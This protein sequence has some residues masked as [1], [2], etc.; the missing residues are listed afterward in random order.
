MLSD[1]G[2][3]AFPREGP[4]TTGEA[5]PLPERGHGPAA[6]QAD[7]A[8]PPQGGPPGSAVPIPGEEAVI[9]HARLAAQALCSRILEGSALVEAVLAVHGHGAQPAAGAALA[10][11]ARL[12]W[13]EGSRR[14]AATRQAGLFQLQ[15]AQQSVVVRLPWKQKPKGSV[16]YRRRLKAG[17]QDTL[18]ISG[19]GAAPSPW[20]KL[21]PGSGYSLPLPSPHAE[22]KLLPGQPTKKPNQPKL[23]R[24]KSKMRMEKN[25]ATHISS[26]LGTHAKKPLL[27][28]GQAQPNSALPGKK[29]SQGQPHAFINRRKRKQ[30]K[31]TLKNCFFSDQAAFPQ[32]DSAALRF[33]TRK[34]GRTVQQALFL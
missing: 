32:K 17:G 8:V 5:G 16:I 4:K 15:R 10:G 21:F 19:Q 33:P 14:A 31:I 6:G 20:G 26:F 9:I 11:E 27:C 7:A 12:Y 25:F 1:T 23:S 22:S 3:P 24:D 34:R 29:L 18:G 13:E 30:M 2:S 28:I